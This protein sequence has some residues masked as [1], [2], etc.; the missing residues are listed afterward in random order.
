MFEVLPGF[1]DFRPS[2]C[3]IRNFLFERWRS[4]A[5]NFGFEEF[6][7]P[8][9]ESLELFT[10][11]SGEEIAE[12]LFAFEDKGGRKIALRPEMTP[13]LVR[14]LGEQAATIK[15]PTKW[16]NITENFR[17][18]RPQKGRLRSFYQFNIDI[19]GE[20]SYTAEAELIA[21]AIRSFQAFGLSREHFYIRLSDRQIW[22]LWLRVFGIKDEDIKVKM[23]SLFDKWERRSHADIEN[24]LRKILPNPV[25]AQN[26]FQA[27]EQLRNAHDVQNIKEIFFKHTQQVD[28][29]QALN[30]RCNE[31][32]L[33]LTELAYLNCSDFI[34]ID[35]SIVRG[36]AYYT[37]FVFEV[38]ETGNQGRALAGGGRYDQLFEK[39]V[40]HA[41]PAVGF[42]AGDVTLTDLLEKHHLLPDLTQTVDAYLVFETS[43]RAI[44]LSTAQDLRSF[45]FSVKYTLGTVKSLSKQ[46]KKAYSENPRFILIF[47]HEEMLQN[48]I[49]VKCI[50]SETK[51]LVAVNDLKNYLQR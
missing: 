9:L 28:I 46:L 1:R 39:L 51:E 23:L 35:L 2:A 11:K 24:D 47:T 31:I 36:L 32:D 29:Q 3:A 10:K 20:E 21:L 41:M 14:I 12:Q 37:G 34:E 49:Q 5:K 50:S 40:G 33:L 25:D 26:F 38:F 8:I 42:A 48:K 6:D 17:Y 13:S 45:N 44:A 19:V 15:R 27:T 16:F 18:E 30:E 43:E 7:G 4:V 22:M